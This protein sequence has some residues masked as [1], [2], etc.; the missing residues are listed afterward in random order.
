MDNKSLAHTTWN[1]KYHI[2]FAPKYRRQIIYGQIKVDVGRILRQLCER[3]GV[4]IIEATACPDHIHMLVSIPPKLSV[5][6]FVG[7]LKGK[8][9]LMIFDRHANLKYKYGNRKFWCRGYYVDTVGR[10]RK[11][12]QEY[13]KNQLQ[14]DILEDQMSMK[15][16]ID[17]FTGEEIKNKK[18]K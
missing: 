6:S 3:K 1:C 17:P 14:E 16:F 18:R 11:I 9:S 4:E 5:S 7:Y 12:I 15:E 8:S 10:N 2:V 13:I